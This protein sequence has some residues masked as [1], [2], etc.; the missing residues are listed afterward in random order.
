MRDREGGGLILMEGLEKTQWITEVGILLHL[1][2]S[3]G[4]KSI[5]PLSC[6]CTYLWLQFWLCSC[7]MQ[8]WRV[9]TDTK[10]SEQQITVACTCLGA[11]CVLYFVC[12]TA[13]CWTGLQV[14]SNWWKPYMENII[15]CKLAHVQNRLLTYVCKTCV[16]NLVTFSQMCGGVWNISIPSNIYIFYV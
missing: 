11:F 15:I 10:E 8:M 6:R 16:P 5:P 1:V 3:P 12:V 7:H 14:N 2:L 4:W 9:Q 13:G